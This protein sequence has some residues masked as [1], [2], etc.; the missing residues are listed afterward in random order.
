MDSE[1]YSLKSPMGSI[2]EKILK[3]KRAEVEA[4]KAA[5]PESEI[6]AALRDAPPVRD[7]FAPLAGGD[8]IQLIAEVK[9]ASPSQGIIRTDF[10]PV[11]IAQTYASAGAACISVLTDVAYFQGSLDYL[12]QIRQS[13]DLPLLRKDFVIDRYQVS[14]ARAAGAD[15][16][17]LIAECL[18]DCPLRQLYGEIIDLGMTPLVELYEPANVTRVLDLGAT[19]IGV[20][21]RDLHSFEVSLERSIRLRAAMPAEIVFVSESGIHCR[22]DVVRLENAGVDAMLVGEHFMRQEDVGAAVRQLLGR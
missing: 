22:D 6:R 9:K 8:G 3:T 11:R 5:R 2:L 12:R 16:V 19:L 17:L 21:N 13:V 1:N 18:E 4:A 15:A 10:D 7:F 20:N 14:E